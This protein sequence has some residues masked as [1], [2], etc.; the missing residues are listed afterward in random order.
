M[1]DYE[2]DDLDHDFDGEMEFK[3]LVSK[4]CKFNV[5]VFMGDGKRWVTGCGLE[6]YGKCANI[7]C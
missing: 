5:C 4:I 1:G 3:L 2:E 6:C 7:C